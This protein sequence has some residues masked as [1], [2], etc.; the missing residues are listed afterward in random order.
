MSH[1]PVCPCPNCRSSGGGFWLLLA[2]A[3]VLVAIGA[4]FAVKAAVAWLAAHVLVDVLAGWLL[5]LGGF[6]V[7]WKARERGRAGRPN[8]S[9]AVHQGGPGP[10]RAPGRAQSRIEQRRGQ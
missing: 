10:R 3:C 7:A 1:G 9:R 2:I 8:S 6:G 5:A 4:Y